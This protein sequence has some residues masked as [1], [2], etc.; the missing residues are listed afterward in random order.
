VE[1]NASIVAIEQTV[2]WLVLCCQERQIW[3][4]NRL[5]HMLTPL[6]LLP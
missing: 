1:C 4:Q 5:F 2:C 6:L 3:Q